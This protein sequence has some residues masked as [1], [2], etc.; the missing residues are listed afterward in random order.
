MGRQSDS[1][2]HLNMPSITLL[3][4]VI[5]GLLPAY[6]LPAVEGPAITGSD[7]LRAFLPSS[8]HT[9]GS[10][11][12]ALVVGACV[13]LKPSVKSPRFALHQGDCGVV[14]QIPTDPEFKESDAAHGVPLLLGRGIHVR[15]PGTSKDWD[16]FPSEMEP[17]GAHCRTQPQ[18]SSSDSVE[19]SATAANTMP[20]EAAQDAETPALVHSLATVATLTD[21]V[22][23]AKAAARIG[24]DANFGFDGA[25]PSRQHTT[26]P[27]DRETGGASSELLSADEF[28]KLPPQQQADLYTAMSEAASSLSNQLSKYVVV[29]FVQYSVVVVL[30]TVVIALFGFS[31]RLYIHLRDLP[32]AEPQDKI[33]L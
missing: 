23:V 2:Q 6:S 8:E 15:F 3:L 5:C 28:L 20:S 30:A 1:T 25:A 26:T 18:S 9:G 16:A 11:D 12:E 27:Q 4:F 24:S 32:V 13:R 29:C 31:V 33:V 21:A 22:H 14:T 10:R 17:C 19:T 7:L